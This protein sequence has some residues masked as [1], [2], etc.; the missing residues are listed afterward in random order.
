[1]AAIAFLTLVDLFAAQAILPALTVAYGVT[2]ASMGVAVNASTLGMAVAGLGV[3]LL[4]RRIPRRAGIL[5]SLVLLAVPTTLLAVAPDLAT[6]TLLRVAQGLCMATAFSLTLAHL[7]EAMGT[8]ASAFAAYITGN[9][10]S[11]LV[12]RLAAAAV[13][14]HFGVSATFYVFAGL[15]IAGAVLVFVAIPAMPRSATEP[16]GVSAPAAIFGHLR[17]PRLLAAF[18]IGF[19]ILFAFIGTFTYVNFILVKP[20]LALG[21]MAVG[22]VYFVFLPSIATTPL[23]GVAVRSWGVRPA[24]SAGMVVALGGV[25]LTLA[26]TLPS[27]MAGLALVGVG[28]F[29]AQAVVTGFVGR[30]ASTERAAASGLYLASYFAGGLAGSAV[31]GRIFDAAGWT[32]SVVGIAA[33]LVLALVLGRFLVLPAAI[34][35]TL[36]ERKPT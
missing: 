9:V 32:A 11:N 14:G 33:A 17:T 26:A 16:S 8:P 29:F 7:G 3:A 21:M 12:G 31:L 18:A 5:A 22:L 36:P 20:P 34:P 4:N 24:F 1:V 13:A 6:F 25:P 2:P 10:A 23:A 27:V 35:S 19:C 30:A 15:N 28:T